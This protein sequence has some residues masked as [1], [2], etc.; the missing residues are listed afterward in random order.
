MSIFRAHWILA[1]FV[2]VLT[3]AAAAQT[4]QST[5]PANS[6][7]PSLASAARDAKSSK[8]RA[9]HVITDE[10][11][12]ARKGPIPR[13]NLDGVDNSDDVLAAISKYREKHNPEEVEQAIHDWYDEHD[14]L[15]NSEIQQGN[16]YRNLRQANIVNGYELCQEG[17]DY[18]KCEKRRQA[19]MRGARLDNEVIRLDS[20]RAARVQQGLIKVR[21]GIAAYNLHYTW[22]KVRQGNGNGSF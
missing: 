16:D 3:C 12:E 20:L 15:L 21:N 1:V 4:S 10:D 6:D 5:P 17:Q 9:A 13:L 18:E 2:A 11:M 22:F 14:T 7:K 8:P 19:E